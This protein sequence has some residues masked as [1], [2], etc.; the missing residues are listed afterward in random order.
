MR[1][2]ENLTK[3]EWDAGMLISVQVIRVEK[4][5]RNNSWTFGTRF[6]CNI[7]IVRKQKISLLKRRH[8]KERKRFLF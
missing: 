5:K 8:V 7:L 2:K 4:K 3:H 6:V 1:N